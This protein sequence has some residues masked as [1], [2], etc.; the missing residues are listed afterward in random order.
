MSGAIVAVAGLGILGR[1]MHFPDPLARALFVLIG[2]T[3][4]GGGLLVGMVTSGLM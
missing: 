2:I 1:A 3:L 4:G